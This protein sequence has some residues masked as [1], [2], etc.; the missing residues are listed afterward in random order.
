[1]LIGAPADRAGLGRYLI[2]L[3]KN[4][5]RIAI[6]VGLDALEYALV[7]G[8]TGREIATQVRRTLVSLEKVL[9]PLHEVTHAYA[10]D[11]IGGI[12]VGKL[13]RLVAIVATE[14]VS[15]VMQLVERVEEQAQA[16]PFRRLDQQVAGRGTVHHPVERD[17]GQSVLRITA[18]DVGM[19]ADK[20]DLAQALA[21][22][23]RQIR[24]DGR[25]G[26]PMRTALGIFDVTVRPTIPA[27][28]LGVR[29]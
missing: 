25:V 10:L 11:G 17:V 22:D 12:E 24:I 4:D 6:R 13:A 26:H 2:G 1:M 9:H 8:R 14:A 23:G 5:R 20:P 16:C 28:T 18:A 7:D 29:R 3:G 27:R 19:H 15:G 21:V